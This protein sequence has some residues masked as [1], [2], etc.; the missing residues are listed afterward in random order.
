MAAR[1][2]ALR[3]GRTLPPGFFIFKD[4]WYSFLLEDESTP[5]AIVRPEGLGQC[6][7]TIKNGRKYTLT[8]SYVFMARCLIKHRESVFFLLFR[9]YISL[10]KEGGECMH[11][12]R[13]TKSGS[14]RGLKIC[15]IL[16]VWLCGYTE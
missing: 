12:V 1:L 7:V 3:P 16:W 6:I 15:L 14:H 8:L 4:Y 11:G 5:R 13:I 10:I 9:E 2:P